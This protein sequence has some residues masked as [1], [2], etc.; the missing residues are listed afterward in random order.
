MIPTEVTIVKNRKHTNKSKNNTSNSYLKLIYII[1]LTIGFFL[2]GVYFGSTFFHTKD[3][4]NELALPA[5][6]AIGLPG[7]TNKLHKWNE[8]IKDSNNLRKNNL[9]NDHIL[10][11]HNSNLSLPTDNT[12]TKNIDFKNSLYA[13]SRSYITAPSNLDD[14][15]IMIATWIYLNKTNNDNDMRT[16]FSNKMPGCDIGNNYIIIIVVVIIKSKLFICI[17]I[18]YSDKLNVIEP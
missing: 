3:N 18:H 9:I 14:D 8:N 2:F 13:T 15:D 10:V 16:I 11:K 12:N 1:P 17:Y 6:S 7:T 4:H 5:V